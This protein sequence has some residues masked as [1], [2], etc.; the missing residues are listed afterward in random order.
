MGMT[1]VYIGL[2]ILVVIL[3]NVIMFTAVHVGIPGPKGDKGDVGNQGLVGKD[4]RDGKDG[5][6]GP[7][8]VRGYTNKR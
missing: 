4:G 8:G 5:E 6:K 7:R 1:V 3:I 2:G